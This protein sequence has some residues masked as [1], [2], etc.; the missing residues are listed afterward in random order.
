MTEHKLKERV[1]GFLSWAKGRGAPIWFLKVHGGAY[2]RANVPDY[3]LCVAGLFVA[4]EL[5]SPTEAATPTLGQARELANIRQANGIECCTNR[6]EDVRSLIFGV[7]EAQGYDTSELRQSRRMG[8]WSA[9][10]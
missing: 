8:H 4:I 9:T 5:K 3:L 7:L 6:I 1:H 10:L 2:Q